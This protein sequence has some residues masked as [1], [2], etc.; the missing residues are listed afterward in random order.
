LAREIV[1]EG[2]GVVTIEIDEE[3]YKFAKRNLEVTGYLDVLLLLGDGSLGYPAEAPYD[4]ICIT[5]AC[6]RIPD[7]LIRQ[8]KREGKLIAPIG[9][10]GLVQDLVLLE[11]AHDGTLKTH[12]VEEVLYV[13]LRGRYGWTG[14]P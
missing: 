1:G 7:P 3:T 11:K 9:S 10:P 8:L 14:S 13:P 4:K 5:A 6:P 12:F 2:G